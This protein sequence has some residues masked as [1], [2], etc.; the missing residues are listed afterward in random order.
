MLEN[1]AVKPLMGVLQ[2][3]LASV[4]V[5]ASC[6]EENPDRARFCLA[7]GAELAPTLRERFTATVTLLFSDIVGSTALGTRLDPE[8]LAHVTGAYY[9]TMRPIVEQHDGR[10]IKFIGD[11]LVAVWG[12]QPGRDDDALRACA[13]AAEMRDRLEPMNDELE[14]TR[15]VRIGARAGITTGPVAGE[16]DNLVAG[17][18]SNV[19]SSVQGAAEPGE[20]LLAE[21]TYDLVRDAVEVDASSEVEIKGKPGLLRVYRLASVLREPERNG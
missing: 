16:G 11:A 17:D 14:R 7:C 4:V 2:P 21:M 12:L 19:A 18:T 3:R 10:V 20:V 13:A 15:G 6:G 9:E 1:Q 8:V 5:W